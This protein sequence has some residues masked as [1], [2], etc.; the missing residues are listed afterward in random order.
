MASELFDLGFVAQT[1]LEFSQFVLL[2]LL[3]DLGF[4][5]FELGHDCIAHIVQANDVIAKLALDRGGGGLAFVQSHHG[6]GEFFDEVARRGPI[7]VATIGART[8]IFGLLFGQIFKLGAFFEAGD[9]GFGL[10]FFFHQNVPGAVLFAPIGGDKLVVFAFDLGIAFQLQDDV[11]D[12]YGDQV[13]FGKQTGG[14]IIANKKTFLLITALQNA[15]DP[16][17]TDLLHWLSSDD[18]SERKVKA[19]TDIYNQ[20]QVREIAELKM[21]ELYNEAINHLNAIPVK[22]EAKQPLKDLAASL[23]NR[24]N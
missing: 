19:V 6:V 21:M 2:N 9:D 7:Q 16:L 24:K 1:L 4:D 17:K 23:M 13:K 20:L 11:L 8:R 10:L 12:V 18:K 22:E 3:N 15:E 5:L 14:D